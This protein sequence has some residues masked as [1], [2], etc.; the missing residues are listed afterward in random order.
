V[1]ELVVSHIEGVRRL[2]GF[3]HAQAIVNVESNLS[4]TAIDIARHMA[5]SSLSNVAMMREDPVAHAGGEM[6]PGS[7]TSVENKPEMVE[8]LKKYLDGGRILVHRDFVVSQPEYSRY[9]DVQEQMIKELRGFTKFTI[10]NPRNPAQR[11]RVSYHGKINGGQDDF[12]MSLAINIFTHGIFM[13]DERYAKHLR[14]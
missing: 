3:Q 13:T 9:T 14:R 10:L 2:P 11:A 8:M 12:V 4:G 7:R 6:R 5:A 1:S